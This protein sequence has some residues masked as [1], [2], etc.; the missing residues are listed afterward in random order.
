M[1]LFFFFFFFSLHPLSLTVLWQ[2]C[3][4]PTGACM[5]APFY[6]FQKEARLTQSPSLYLFDLCLTTVEEVVWMIQNL[7]EIVV[8]KVLWFTQ[9]PGRQRRGSFSSLVRGVPTVAWAL[10]LRS[11]GESMWESLYASSTANERNIS[12]NWHCVRC[13][14]IQPW[15]TFLGNQVSL[16]VL[17]RILKSVYADLSWTKHKLLISKVSCFITA[18]KIGGHFAAYK[19][20]F[21]SA[22][23]PNP[24]WEWSPSVTLNILN[25]FYHSWMLCLRKPG[26][27]KHKYLFC[28]SGS[29]WTCNISLIYHNISMWVSRCLSWGMGTILR[30]FYSNNLCPWQGSWN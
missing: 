11:T 7:E 24:L 23:N 18:F 30:F 14:W 8:S 4:S 20:H 27:W 21:V 9:F 10:H 5:A 2:S 25:F 19:I 28:L 1:L 26:C 22:S 17:L 3:H 13:Q 29:Q 16:L 15:E 6:Q 12:W